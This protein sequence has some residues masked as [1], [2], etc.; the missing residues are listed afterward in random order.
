ML[1]Y[2]HNGLVHIRNGL[3]H[4]CNG[5]FMI[6]SLTLNTELSPGNLRLSII[7]LWILLRSATYFTGSL[8]YEWGS[9]GNGLLFCK[10]LPVP[11]ELLCLA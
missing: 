1:V 6:L 3:V 9:V 7:V 2:T 4:I 5:F 11:V 10:W 8:K